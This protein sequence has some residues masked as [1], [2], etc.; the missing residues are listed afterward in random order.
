MDRSRGK[1]EKRSEKRKKREV[2]EAVRSGERKGR[3]RRKEGRGNREWSVRR[4]REVR[5]VG[6]GRA[7]GGGSAR[8]VARKY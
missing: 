1:R 2:G 8:K 7:G 4:G 3:K 6:H 5:G